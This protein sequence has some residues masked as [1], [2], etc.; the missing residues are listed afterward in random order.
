MPLLGELHFG[1]PLAFDLGVFLVV[2]GVTCKTVFALA[3]STEGLGALVREEE[4]RYS[5]PV[6]SPIDEL[7]AETPEGPVRT[8]R[9]D[10]HAD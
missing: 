2:V 7:I 10:D 3:K 5:S 6:E 9:E 8:R 4:A 1:T